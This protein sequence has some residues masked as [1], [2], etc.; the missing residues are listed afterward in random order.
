[1]EQFEREQ[2]HPLSLE[3]IK[4]IAEEEIAKGSNPCL[5]RM[6][7]IETRAKEDQP[8]KIFPAYPFS[9]LPGKDGDVLVLF[10]VQFVMQS[11]NTACIT[12]SVKD[13]GVTCRFWNLPPTEKAMDAVP[14]AD[15]SG[16]Q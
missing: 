1:M 6:V 13:I 12:I 14:L 4:A 2:A 16:V 10:V 8:R 11:Y 9:I 7:F 3:E 15:V 5:R